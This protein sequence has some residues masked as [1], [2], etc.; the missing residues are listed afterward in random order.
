MSNSEIGIVTATIQGLNDGP[1]YFH[2]KCFWAWEIDFKNPSNLFVDNIPYIYLHEDSEKEAKKACKKL[3]ANFEKAGIFEGDRIAIITKDS[4]VKAI[5]RLG[6]KSWIDVE[7]KFVIK[8]FKELDLQVD[9][10]T[11]F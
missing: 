6:G 7:N 5:G 9:S 8:T 11:V 4:N 2:S 1:Y 3:K 10:L